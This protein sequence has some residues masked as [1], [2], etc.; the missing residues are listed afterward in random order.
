MKKDKKDD[1]KETRRTPRPVAP[2]YFTQTGTEPD[3]KEVLTLKR[4]TS[5][6]G[7]IIPA[8]YTGISAK[9]QRKLAREIKKARFMALLPFTDQHAL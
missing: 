8:K 6:R 1:K 5:D 7:K 3:Y 4:F 2:C 9:N